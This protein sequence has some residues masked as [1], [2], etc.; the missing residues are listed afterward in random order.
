MQLYFESY[1]VTISLDRKSS[2]DFT[3]NPNLL[4]TDLNY[5]YGGFPL[6]CGRFDVPNNKVDDLA[7]FITR[8]LT[9]S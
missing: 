3:I 1:E 9:I 5:L 8:G 7:A 2:Q 6:S 4:Y